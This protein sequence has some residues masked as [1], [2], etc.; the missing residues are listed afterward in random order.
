M[1]NSVWRLGLVSL[2]SALLLI[3]IGDLFD[4]SRISDPG[5]V[6]A[7]VPGANDLYVL[8]VDTAGDATRAGVGVGD[9]LRLEDHGAASRL[10]VAV[11]NGLP[12][13]ARIAMTDL[14]TARPFTIVMR[15]DPGV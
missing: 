12:P 8:Q 6:L 5:V 4:G 15:P 9:V 7:G 10:S 14:R 2:L 13:G 3:S 11:G 1:T